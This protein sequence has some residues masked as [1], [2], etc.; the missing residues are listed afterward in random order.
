MAEVSGRM[1]YMNYSEK[2]TERSL[3]CCVVTINNLIKVKQW[4]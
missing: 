1:N 2:K 4:I 3:V